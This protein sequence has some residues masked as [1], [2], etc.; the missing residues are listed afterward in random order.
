MIHSTLTF[1]SL[2]FWCLIACC[3]FVQAQNCS[4]FIIHNLLEEPIP[5][6]TVQVGDEVVYSDWKGKVVLANSTQPLLK[7]HALGYKDTLV[8]TAI[9]KNGQVIYMM[10]GVEQLMSVEVGGATVDLPELIEQV[11]DHSWDVY[12]DGYETPLFVSMQSKVALD[13]VRYSAELDSGVIRYFSNRDWFPFLEVYAH[14]ERFVW[15]EHAADLNQYVRFG[16]QRYIEYH[17]PLHPMT[18]PFSNLEDCDIKVLRIENGVEQVRIVSDTN[19]GEYFEVYMTFDLEN[20]L[21]LDVDKRLVSTA[22]TKPVYGRDTLL[23]LSPFTLHAAYSFRTLNDVYSLQSTEI[24]KEERVQDLNT[25]HIVPIQSELSIQV[26]GV[27]E[28]E[29][30]HSM[31]SGKNVYYFP[32]SLRISKWLDGY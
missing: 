23:Y 27:D 29:T 13:G 6:V 30:Y 26:L 18:P 4:E 32:T 17:F 7:L 11:I 5:Y 22:E 24:A 20:S 8:S 21:V 16:A 1:Q 9:L 3:N 10:S 19:A 15:A 31:K 2:L 28:Q 25:G 14:S 12:K